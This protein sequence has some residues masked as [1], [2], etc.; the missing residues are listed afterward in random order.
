MLLGR[1]CVLLPVRCTAGP[2]VGRAAV[3]ALC[4][5]SVP[6]HACAVRSH[7]PCVGCADS[8]ETQSTCPARVC[9]C[10][11]AGCARLLLIPLPFSAGPCGVGDRSRASGAVR[12]RAVLACVLLSA[13]LRMGAPSRVVRLPYTAPCPSPL[14]PASLAAPCS[15]CL[16]SYRFCGRRP[17]RRPLSLPWRCNWQRLRRA[18]CVASRAA[19]GSGRLVL[20]RRTAANGTARASWMRWTWAVCR[21]AR[22]HTVVARKRSTAFPR[23]LSV[24]SGAPRRRRRRSTLPG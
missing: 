23:S 20:G 7:C 11:A 22:L 19:F 14:G 4:C 2:R 16:Y 8:A 1:P 9:P 24:R 15:E 10:A 5:R 6:S 17:L 21:R 18:L 12:D 13:G 3:S